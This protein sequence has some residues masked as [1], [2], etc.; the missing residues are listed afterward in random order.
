VLD[1]DD[2]A[3]DAPIERRTTPSHAREPFRSWAWKRHGIR[4]RIGRGWRLGQ[5]AAD[6][7]TDSQQGDVEPGGASTE[8]LVVSAAVDHGRSHE[9]TDHGEDVDDQFGGLERRLGLGG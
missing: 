4:R 8:C 7:V 3:N 6:H 9:N 1:D 5:P 2:K